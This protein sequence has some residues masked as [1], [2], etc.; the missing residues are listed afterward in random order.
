MSLIRVGAV[1]VAALAVAAP[2]GAATTPSLLP[3]PSDAYTARSSSTP[4][5]RVLAFKSAQMPKNNKGVHV[6]PR[7][8]KGLDG[9]S[10]GSVI[11]AKV[12]GLQTS[13]ALKRTNPVGLSDISRYTKADAPVLVVDAKTGKRWPVW[14]ELDANATHTSQRLLEIHPAKN[15]TEGRALRRRAAQPAQGGAARRS[16]G[17]KRSRFRRA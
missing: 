4:T 1:V 9:F 10:P 12:P 2:A 7:Q 3:F 15:F 5:G 17:P 14:A 6:D 11:L 16:S 8:Y 13:A